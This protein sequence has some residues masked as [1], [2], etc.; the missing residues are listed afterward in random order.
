L[1]IVV[2]TYNVKANKW[3][4]Q[5]LSKHFLIAV[6]VDARNYFSKLWEYLK[7]NPVWIF[8]QLFFPV[9]AFFAGKSR[10]K[11]ALD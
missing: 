5:T 9:I 4:N 7:E 8:T 2:Y 11:K 1:T 6:E 10:G 3:S